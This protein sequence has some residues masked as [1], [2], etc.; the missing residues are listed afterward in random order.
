[1]CIIILPTSHVICFIFPLNF[2]FP[3]CHCIVSIQLLLLLLVFYF[4]LF[5]LLFFLFCFFF[6]C[7]SLN[8]V[9]WFQYPIPTL[10]S[11][12]KVILM[13]CKIIIYASNNCWSH[14]AVANCKQWYFVCPNK[15]ELKLELEAENMKLGLFSKSRK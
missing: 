7:I 4:I 10:L 14:I 8:F 15:L 5:S 1:M 11:V 13:Y 3:D 9:S 12:L 6:F 2:F